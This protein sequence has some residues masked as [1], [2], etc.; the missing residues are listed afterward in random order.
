[1]MILQPAL[2]RPTY[3]KS[4][5]QN[6]QQRKRDHGRMR[7]IEM[8]HCMSEVPRVADV[9]GMECGMVAGVQVRQGEPRLTRSP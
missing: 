6:E 2:R 8:E 1:M 9:S 5:A 3:N 4:T 7:A